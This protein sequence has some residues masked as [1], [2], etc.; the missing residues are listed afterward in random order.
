M[1]RI[2]ISVEGP[3]EERFI[4][5]VL[6]P[7]LSTYSIYPTPISMG[8]DIKLDRVR[9]ELQRIAHN[10]DFVSTLYDFYGFKGKD[11]NE[12]KQSLEMKII[13]HIAENIRPKVIPY[14]QMYE[15]EGL[16]FSDPEV[17]EI[18]I[19]EEGIQNWANSIL[20]EFRNNP[21]R[22][23]N[24]ILTSP[25]KRLENKTKYRKTTHGPNIAAEIGID[26]LRQK[27]AGF[28]NWITRLLETTQ[29]A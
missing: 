26:L 25:S 7:Y 24:S 16:L 1:V 9:S 21:E 4:T 11:D 28:N 8:G 20:N 2:G 13:N 12:T 6:T 27:C 18:E 10:F 17:M 15:F 22:I 23:N 19:G 14:I 3:T 29:Q 5:K